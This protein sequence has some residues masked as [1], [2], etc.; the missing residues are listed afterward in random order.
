MISEFIYDWLKDIVVFFI[1]ITLIELIMPKGKLK[2]YMNFIIG[3]ILIFMVISPF[4]KL[5]S[6]DFKLEDSRIDQYQKQ[7]IYDID[8]T[9]EQTE[10]I[11]DLYIEKIDSEI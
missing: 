4:L 3:L 7:E 6:I 10:R 8:F 1:I 9:K 11:E 5:F 2:R